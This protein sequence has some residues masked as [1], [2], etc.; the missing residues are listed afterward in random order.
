MKTDGDN[1]DYWLAIDKEQINALPPV[2]FDEKVYIIDALS[3]V[4]VAV[5]YLRKCPVVG[6]DTETRPSF[7][8]GE[9]HKVSLLQLSSGTD[10]FL[11]RLN[12]LGL[13]KQLQDYLEDE[14]CLKVGLSIHDDFN[15]MRRLC[16]FTPRGFVELQE[17]AAHYCIADLSLQKI[18]AI[19]FG[20]KI[21]KSQRLTN[22]EAPELTLAQQRY[23]AIDAWACVHIYNQLNDGLFV[24]EQSP[25]KKYPEDGEV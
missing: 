8:R 18:Y 21:S 16:E 7:H 14:T 20:Q 2:D 4:N 13:P 6:F 9:H 19:V 25:Y 17:M 11:F 24:P 15:V 5:A 1:R 3:Q 12:K 23:A 22:W 10:T